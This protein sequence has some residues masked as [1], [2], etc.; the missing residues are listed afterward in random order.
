MKQTFLLWAR[1]L[2]ALMGVVAAIPTLEDVHPSD[3][4]QSEVLNFDRA[5]PPAD[6]YLWTRMASS[7]GEGSSP[8]L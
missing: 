6:H 1:R 3:H 8:I 2:G 4:Y 7:S 5:A